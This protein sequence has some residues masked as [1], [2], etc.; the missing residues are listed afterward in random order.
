MPC[1]PHPCLPLCRGLVSNDM[2]P[3]WVKGWEVVR[4]AQEDGTI[5]AGG[6]AD[7]GLT[8]DLATPSFSGKA[9]DFP[10]VKADSSR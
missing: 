3:Q 4:L 5:S 2:A 6:Q 7:V 8:F 10:F 1:E 9:M